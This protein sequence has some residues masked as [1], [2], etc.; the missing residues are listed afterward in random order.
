ME[1]SVDPATAAWEE[2]QQSPANKES[3][4]NLQFYLEAKSNRENA[5]KHFLTAI[6]I[7]FEGL[8]QT[9]DDLLQHSVVAIHNEMEE[10]LDGTESEVIST[11]QSN[12]NRRHTMRQQMDQANQVWVQQYVQ[13]CNKIAPPDGNTLVRAC[14]LH[15]S[16]F[17]CY[18]YF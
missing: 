15:T 14:I 1:N 3:V 7:Y 9:M 2:F 16:R 5:K 17:L 18:I 13:I 4:P 6:E 10:R 12:H 8:T 11:L